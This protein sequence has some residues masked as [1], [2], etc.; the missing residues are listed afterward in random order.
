M[1]NALEN[2]MILWSNYIMAINSEIY[3]D[4]NASFAFK[5]WLQID[6]IWI[7]LPVFML[8]AVYIPIILASFA[9][10]DVQNINIVHLIHNHWFQK[11]IH[12]I[13]PNAGNELIA[14]I[15]AA[16]G[17]FAIFKIIR[18]FKGSL[19]VAAIVSSYFI[20]APVFGLQPNYFNSPQ[21]GIFAALYGLS[22]YAC[23]KA[24]NTEKQSYLALSFLLSTIICW[25]RPLAIW[26][27][28]T[29]YFAV[30][31]TTKAFE[32]RTKWG[33]ISALCWG[34]ALFYA[35]EFSKFFKDPNFGWLSP[36]IGA[37]IN[38]NKPSSQLSENMEF[39]YY[40]F[41]SLPMLLLMA[42]AGLAVFLL[43]KSQN[44][45]KS[46]LI[47]FVIFFLFGLFGSIGYKDVIA[48]RFLIDIFALS[49]IGIAIANFEN[50]KNIIKK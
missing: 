18:I 47:V 9:Q 8:F 12:K 33:L 31:L 3:T 39:G 41:N 43:I 10:I 24:I 16:I 32:D 2:D 13:I 26:P 22:F 36:K 29:V 46:F 48:A 15:P 30:L 19:W 1:V 27:M 28:F 6:K 40:L 25:F 21:D 4:N 45:K 49:I 38:I 14:I 44:F 34:P 5:E 37:F 35:H 11:L 23:L 20:A 42:F 17:G 50:I 7:L